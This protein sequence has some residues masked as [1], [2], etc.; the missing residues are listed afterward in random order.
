MNDYC[1]KEIEQD[2]I[3]HQVSGFHWRSYGRSF[4]IYFVENNS[5]VIIYAE[6]SGVNHL[7]IL[8]YGETE[9][10]SKRYYP[11][12][13]STE[14]IPLNERIRI[15]GLLAEWLANKGMRHDIKIGK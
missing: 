8:V 6:M 7:D 15:Q 4:N 5:I 14:G 10:I 12:Q 3:D 2:K 9:H 13:N 11:C 1:F